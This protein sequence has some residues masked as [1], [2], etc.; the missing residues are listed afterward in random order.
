[1]RRRVVGAEAKYCRTN[2]ARFAGQ[3]LCRKCQGYA[4][5]NQ[6]KR[7]SGEKAVEGG[8]AGAVEVAAR[9]AVCGTGVDKKV[10]AFCRFNSKGFEGRVLCRECQGRTAKSA[11]GPKGN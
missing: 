9:C 8:V 7:E 10:V 5:Q 4:P 1:M 11:Q 3:L 2:A 6:K